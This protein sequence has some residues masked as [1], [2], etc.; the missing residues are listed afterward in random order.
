[1]S[2]K[3]NTSETKIIEQSTTN[4]LKYMAIFVMHYYNCKNST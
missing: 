4:I 2:V 1:M 3:G